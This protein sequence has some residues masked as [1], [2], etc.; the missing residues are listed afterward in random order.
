MRITFTVTNDL[1]QDQRM[2][3]I[4]S[5]LS[6]A[7]YDVTL[8]GRKRPH[9]LPLKERDYKQKRLYC[10]FEKG[11]LFY[12][13]YNVRL[14]FFLFFKKTD[15]YG[16]IDLDTILPNF[17]AAK[18][19]SRQITYDAHEYFSQLEEVMARPI[20]KAIWKWVERQTVP[21]IKYQYTVSNGYKK[22]FEKEYPA[23]FEIIRNATVLQELKPIKKEEKYILYQG[24][25]NYGRGLEELIDAMAM[26]DCKLIIC[27]VGDVLDP[28]KHKV[29]ELNIYDKVE[30]KGFVE[31][32]ELRKY[33]LQAT[34]GITL[35]SN[36]GLSNQYS[37]ANRFFDYMHAAVPQIAMN[38]PEYI[39]FNKENEIAFLI[40]RLDSNSIASAINK[41][42]EDREYYARLANNCLVAREKNC[43]Q[44]EEKKLVKI[45]QEIENT[46][47]AL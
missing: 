36:E 32:E 28:L 13:E 23:R 10:F 6:G 41:L 20:T 45:Y 7:G 9:S 12:L 27:G 42:L 18:F 29:K 31:P 40:E 47:C 2:N 39:E 21:N 1:S 37:L 25:V 8:I 15:V 38:Y 5:S 24:A 26:I 34:V 44:E 19:R 11:K 14:F 43:W 33:T 16:A 30:F 46:R 3:R 22:L 35:F 17:Y 4:C